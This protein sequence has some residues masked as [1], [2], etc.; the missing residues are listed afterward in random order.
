VRAG[1]AAGAAADAV[2]GASV[3]AGMLDGAVSDTGVILSADFTSLM[4]S[5]VF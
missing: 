2:A 4:V 5:F 3:V 1:T